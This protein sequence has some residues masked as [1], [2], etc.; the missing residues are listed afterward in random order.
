MS[1]MLSI[2]FSA[3]IFSL[4]PF[5]CTPFCYRRSPI[6][7]SFSMGRRRLENKPVRQISIRI[8]SHVDVFTLHRELLQSRSEAIRHA[9]MLRDEAVAFLIEQGTLQAKPGRTPGAANRSPAPLNF[10][11]LAIPDDRPRRMGE[12]GEQN[13][14]PGSALPGHQ[15]GGRERIE[16]PVLIDAPDEDSVNAP[17]LEES[18]A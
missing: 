9:R 15:N 18:I 4:F 10:P 3:K 16:W 14:D 7:I 13:P 11:T 17:P 1:T 8:G 12:A 6:T 5:S 2:H